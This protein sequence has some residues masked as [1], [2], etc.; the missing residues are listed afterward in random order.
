MFI[1]P[2]MTDDGHDT[3]VTV[4][5]AWANRFLTPLLSNKN[6]MNNTLVLLTFDEDETYSQQNKVYAVLLG[7]AVPIA[8]Q[9]TTDP[10]FYT[11]YSEISTVEAN[12]GLHTLGRWDVGANVFKLVAN[13]TGDTIRAASNPALAQT[14]LNASY[15]GIFNT[16]TKAPLPVPNTTLVVNGRSVLPAIASVWGGQQCHTYYDGR[17]SPPSA[18]YPPQYPNAGKACTVV[19]SNMGSRGM[20]GAE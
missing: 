10:S 11:H 3:S 4:A 6:F 1:T 9:G 16:R 15:P 8:L 5:G 7:D 14:Y 2:N 18:A 17:V 19:R 20:D 13:K 12:W